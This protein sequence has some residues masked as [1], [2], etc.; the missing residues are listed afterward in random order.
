MSFLTEV[1]AITG[2]LTADE[3]TDLNVF[4]PEGVRFITKA[5]MQND[6]IVHQL[7]KSVDVTN[8]NGYSLDNVLNITEVVRKDNDSGNNKK[9]LCQR[10]PNIRKY[11]LSDT[12]SIYFTNKYGPKYYI[13]NGKL[14]IYPDPTASEFGELQVIEPD[15]SVTHN[16]NS[17]DI[18]NF[19]KEY[20]RGV[21][22][23]SAMQCIR[24][25]MHDIVEP[26]VAGNTT[27][28]EL[29]K[30]EAGDVEQDVDRLDYDKWWDMVGDYLADEDVELATAMLNNIAS[31]LGAYQTELGSSSTQY[32]WHESQYVKLQQELIQWL[33]SYIPLGSGGGE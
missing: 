25:K 33:G 26:N 11:D 24:K 7:T 5:L 8:G 1:E 9:R 32:N 14:F 13:Q 6:S 21:I 10:I 3:K 18:D 23:Y 19:P 4:L 27:V 31:Y 22:L 30:I 15:S 20:E 29:T 2:T 12:N 16:Q 28:G 17:G